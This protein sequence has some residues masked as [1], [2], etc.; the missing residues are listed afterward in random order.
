MLVGAAEVFVDAVIRFC[1]NS[2]LQ[3]SWPRYLPTAMVVDPFWA[4]LRELI[5]SRLSPIPILRPWR[6]GSLRRIG[7]LKYLVPCCLDENGE[8]LFEDLTDE[9]YLSNKYSEE[10]V[11][12]LRTV[13]LKNISINEVWDRVRGDLRS[14]YSKMK[15][16]QT[17]ADWHSRSAQMILN[18]ANG[19]QAFNIVQAFEMLPLKDKSWTSIATG[20]VYYHQ[21]AGIDVPLDLGL[22]IL[23]PEAAAHPV[24]KELF[25]AVGVKACN[26]NDIQKLIV[27]KYAKWNNVKL[28]SSVS[29]I[30]FLFHLCFESD[31]PIDKTMFLFDTDMNPVYQTRVTL[32]QPEIIVNDV[33]FNNPG[34]YNVAALRLGQAGS[35]THNIHII[36]PAYME[37]KDATSIFHALSWKN[38][39]HKHA[40]VLESPRLI[41]SHNPLKLSDLFTWIIKERRDAFLGILKTHWKTYSNFMKPEIVAALQRVKLKCNDEHDA[42]LQDTFVPLPELLNVAANLGVKKNVR[43]LRL[44]SEFSEESPEGW[45]FLKTFGAGVSADLSFYLEALR[46]ITYNDLASRRLLRPTLL[47]IYAAIEERAQ[48]DDY[49]RLRYVSTQC[50]YQSLIEYQKIF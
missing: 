34:A 37:S 9:I 50:L 49:T 2:T 1:E 6:G 13:G 28:D 8:P 7:K 45:Y 25:D 30:R 48:V 20:P 5:T 17:G 35:S 19:N 27:R 24:R 15:S 14:P 16:Q 44:P 22:R 21:I 36:H 38:W 4:Q 46:A 40:R 39:L 33:Y 10:E 11:C 29:H 23:A 3:Y 43:F 18:Q 32:G 41:D 31:Q 47:N 26:S 42:F 12:I